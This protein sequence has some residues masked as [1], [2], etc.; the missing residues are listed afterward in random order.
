MVFILDSLA[1]GDHNDARSMP[2][3]IQAFLNVA[4]EIDL[5]LPPGIP[6]HK[7]PIRDFIQIPPA[8]LREAVD[9]I[10]KVIPGC[11]ILVSC[12]AGVGRSSS[13]VISYLC[14]VGFGFGQAVEFVAVKKPDISI[15]PRLI[16]SIREIG[17]DSGKGCQGI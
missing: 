15:L 14:T 17:G 2:P 7:V 13:V 9:W 10:R 16:S 8:Q 3:G 5:Q 12:N 6:S 4:D 1:I 11:R